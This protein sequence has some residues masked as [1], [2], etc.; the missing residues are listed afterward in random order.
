MDVKN[1]FKSKWKD[2]IVLI[3][4]AFVLAFAV[5]QVFG[6]DKEQSVS[7]TQTPTSEEE[8]K[9]TQLLS[10]IQGVGEVSVMIYQT[11]E[12]EKSVVVV[13]DGANDLQVNM[14]VRE[15]AA[16]ALGT[17]KNAVKIYLKKD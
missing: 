15:A 6:K 4:L 12:G 11:K 8:L 9:L 3:L 13:C 5:W 1:F 14:N 2:T 16:A 7:I 17:T 10:Q